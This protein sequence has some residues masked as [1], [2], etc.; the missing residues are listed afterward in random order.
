V[1]DART[2]LF[3]RLIDDAG[4]FPPARKPITEA[5]ADH[6]RAR[7]GETASIL[8]R[9]LCPARRLSELAEA[10]AEPDWEL[11]AIASPEGDW[12]A[13]LRAE[14]EEVAGY[15]GPGAIRALELPL[16]GEPRASEAIAIAREE[17]GA[18][19][20]EPSIE[21][22]LELPSPSVEVLEALA[23]A[24]EGEDGPRP[25][26]KLR[27]G[28]PKAS[29][30]P[31]DELVAGFIAGCR[32]LGV[33]FKATAGLHHPFREADPETGALQHGFVNLLA[34]AA[35][36]AEDE[37]EPGAEELAPVIAERDPAAF[38]L[39]ASGIAWRDRPAGAS[40]SARARELFRSYGCCSFSEP[41]EGLIEHGLLESDLAPVEAEPGI[42]G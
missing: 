26:A 34:A 1:S 15:D 2:I 37:G 11:G 24:R 8:G 25:A 35:L 16:R 29:S 38:S 5:V 23:A 32:R 28:G 10:G 42:D 22:F 27:C 20:L 6:R 30:I 14:L 40:A 7:A 12:R 19:S 13:A 41:V 3:R 36:S 39:D 4:L 31:A 33:P 17:A 21:L 18:A 9:F